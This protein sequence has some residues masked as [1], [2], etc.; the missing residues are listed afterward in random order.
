LDTTW[1][2]SAVSVPS[3]LAPILT[4]VVIWCRVVAP[5]NSSSRVHSHFTGRPSSF[6]VANSG[7]SSDTI[8]CLPPKPPP[9]RS[10][11]TWIWLAGT[12]IR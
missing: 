6:M 9:T 8:S 4:L 10:V 3:F 5:M 11:K 7:R 2:S 1:T 12:P